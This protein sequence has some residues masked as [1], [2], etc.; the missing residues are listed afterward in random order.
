MQLAITERLARLDDAAMGHHFHVA[1]RYFP[2]RWLAIFGRPLGKI[3]AIEQ[4]NGIGW[5]T[6]RRIL[7]A[8]RSRLNHRR[9]RT[10][11]IVWLP[12]RIHLRHG[13]LRHTKG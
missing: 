7:R 10:V 3:L 11:R 2:L 4:H 5:R 8:R 1:I 6:P 12:A 13:K 9:Q